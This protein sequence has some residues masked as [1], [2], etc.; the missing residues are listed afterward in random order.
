MSKFKRICK[1]LLVT[2]AIAFSFYHLMAPGKQELDPQASYE[3][4]P[5]QQEFLRL[6]AARYDYLALGDTD[7]RNSKIAMFALNEKTLRS[8]REGGDKNVFLEVAPVMQSRLDALKYGI[9]AYQ[10][11]DNNMWLCEE[12][13]KTRLNATFAQSVQV[14]REMNFIAADKRFDGTDPLSQST[15]VKLLIGMPLAIYYQIYGCVDMPAFVPGMII[16]IFT[17]L[18]DDLGKAIKNDTETAS[19]IES[20]E[21]GGTIFYGA[22]HFD[23]NPEKDGISMVNLF[24]QAGKSVAVVNIFVDEKKHQDSAAQDRD[25]DAYL[26]INPAVNN[27][28]GIFANNPELQKILDQARQNIRDREKKPA[29]APAPQR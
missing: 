14:N 16:G 15:N 18:F 21:G 4:S 20:H 12:E 9:H 7:H 23:R 5:L 8:V 22:A 1:D 28:D 3:P 24:E 27:T 25:A 6:A 17:G 29:P 26:Y 11:A 10:H 2:S 13:V 19:Y